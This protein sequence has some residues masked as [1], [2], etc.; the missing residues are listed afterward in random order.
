MTSRVRSIQR[1]KLPV[2]KNAEWIAAHYVEWLGRIMRPFLTT[3][4]E[5]DG[6]WTAI[7]HP[8]RI[9]L[10]TLTFEPSKSS[11]DRRMYFITGGRLAGLL[12]RRTAR[13]EFR[14]LLG[15][16]FTLAAI[17]DFNPALPWIFYRFTH[18]L[19]HFLVMK[20]F[21]R[22]LARLAAKS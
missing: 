9:E 21:Q 22:H 2:G 18:A 5:P 16:R 17:H 4:T 8:G 20:G 14:D 3:S 15:G 19:V 6:S 1:F 13:L 10:L 11:P 12:G 7:A